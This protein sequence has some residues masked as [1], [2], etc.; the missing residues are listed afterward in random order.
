MQTQILKAQTQI[1]KAQMQILKNT[2]ANTANKN[3]KIHKHNIWIANINFV[4]FMVFIFCNSNKI[5]NNSN[6]FN[7]KN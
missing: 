7:K 5:C 1:L 2:N 4:N 6:P 3:I